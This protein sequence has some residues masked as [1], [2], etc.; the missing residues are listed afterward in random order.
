MME[1]MG[2]E[3]AL[4]FNGLT[5]MLVAYSLGKSCEYVGKKLENLDTKEKEMNDTF[6]LAENVMYGSGLIRYFCALWNSN[7]FDPIYHNLLKLTSHDPRTED[8]FLAL[9]VCVLAGLPFIRFFVSSYLKCRK[10]KKQ[11]FCIRDG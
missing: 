10:H 1:N 7:C 2:V 4:I 6:L 11:G 9:A 8:C 3:E 5:T